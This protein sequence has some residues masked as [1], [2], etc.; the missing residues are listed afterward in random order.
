MPQSFLCEHGKLAFAAPRRDDATTILCD[1]LILLTSERTTLVLSPIL[2]LVGIIRN[3]SAR[4]VRPWEYGG[5]L[6]L[7]SIGGARRF[8][9]AR[10]GC[11]H[12]AGRFFSQQ[13]NSKLDTKSG[14]LRVPRDLAGELTYLIGTVVLVDYGK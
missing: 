6:M 10:V 9:S 3:I 1:A 12:R 11:P 2:D 14:L 5:A 4:L 13:F 8:S 7:I